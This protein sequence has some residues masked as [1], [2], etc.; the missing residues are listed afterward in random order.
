MGLQSPNGLCRLRPIN[1]T[2]PPVTEDKTMLILSRKRSQSIIISDDIEI[3]VISIFGDKVRL[4][5]KAPRCVA[6]DRKEV[7]IAK[8]KGQPVHPGESHA[9]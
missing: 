5:I 7:R 4:G 3:M 1:G 6:V 9:A 2:P 8:E